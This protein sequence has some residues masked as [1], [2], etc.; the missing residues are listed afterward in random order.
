MTPYVDGMRR[1]F[2]FSGRS[3]RW[4]FWGF[5]LFAD[6]LIPIGVVIAANSL[7]L[8]PREL[9]VVAT[10]VS[11]I[12]LIPF[13][14]VLTRRV[15]D[16][17]RHMKWILWFFLPVIGWVIL[18]VV[19]CQPS[20]EGENDYG[21]DPRETPQPA[22]RATQ[23]VAARE[24]VMTAPRSLLPVEELEKLQALRASGAIDESE[25]AAMKAKLLGGLGR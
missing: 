15:H 17:G 16:T 18:L 19:A 12:H 14:A 3:S 9:D 10:V 23:P 22:Y 11:G 8:W 7:R 20:Q 24:P 5:V 6:V 13:F 2:D 4:Q 25:F 1:Y 21:P